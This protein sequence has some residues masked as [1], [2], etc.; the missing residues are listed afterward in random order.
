MTKPAYLNIYG[1]RKSLFSNSLF[2]GTKL[3]EEYLK[4]PLGFLDIGGRG[5]IHPIVDGLGRLVKV[6]SFD[7]DPDACLGLRGH[8][9]ASSGDVPLRVFPYALGRDSEEALLHVTQNPAASSLLEPD[10]HY[11]ERYRV[12]P[13]GMTG[14][15][16]S[17]NIH[18]LDSLM[19][20]DDVNLSWGDA[21]FIKLDVQ[22]GEL[23]VLAGAQNTIEKDTVA[24]FCEVEFFQL[25]KNQPLFSDIEVYLRKFGFS[26]FGFFNLAS[27]ST[28]KIVKKD[29]PLVRERL[30]WADAI[31]FKDPVHEDANLGSQT[32]SFSRRNLFSLIL[33][34]M[35]LEYYDYALEVASLCNKRGYLDLDE[36][37]Q[38]SMLCHKLAEFNN[39]A[40]S[41][42]ISNLIKLIHDD[43]ANA[44][45]NLSHFIDDWR[46][47]ADHRDPFVK[48]NE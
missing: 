29:S 14:H 30:Y 22:G 47:Y 24:I 6:S 44:A 45:K 25:Y 31:F 13:A 43:H 12:T 7:A 3:Y 23:D 10:S 11:V 32:S 38:L 28:Q 40:R 33:I 35:L 20:K 48:P 2:L 42:S 8:S 17:V 21:E 41:S 27:K 26:F 34:A 39:E 15:T 19:N 36:V 9:G 5:G 18:T 4:M 37:R 1:E 16:I 46:F